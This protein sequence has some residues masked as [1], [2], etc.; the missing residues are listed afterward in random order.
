MKKL[1]NIGGAV[2][3]SLLVIAVLPLALPKL[4]G[5]T[6]YHIMTGSMEPAIPTDSVVYV[7]ACEP[8]KLRVGDVIT[9]RL[10]S[11]SELVQTHRIAAIDPDKALLTTKG[12]ANQSVDMT[13][14]KT[15]NVLGR[16]AFHIPQYGKLA[17]YIRT[18]EGIA[19]CIAVFAAVLILWITADRIEPK[20]R[21]RSQ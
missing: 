16:V 10:G 4:L 18:S 19:S 5:F 13:R 11:E 14:V 21:K 17:E 6:P 1:L 2:L 9:Y 8:S 20:E 7:K 15:E 3:L 12:D